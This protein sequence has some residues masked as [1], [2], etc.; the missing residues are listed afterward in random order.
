MLSDISGSIDTLEDIYEII[1]DSIADDPPSSVKDGFIIKDGFNETIDKLRKASKDG[2]KWIAE[3]EEKEREY[4][5][6]KSLKIGYTKVFGYY[7]EITNANLSSVP[8]DRY[9]RK[10]TLSNAERYITPELKEMETEITGAEEKVVQLEYQVFCEIRDK[11]AG[12]IERIQK[13]SWAIASIDVLC[14]LAIAAGEN[15]YIRP[16]ITNNGTILIKDGRH[17]VVEKTLPNNMFVPNDTLLDNQDNRISIITGPNMAGKS[18]Y[19]RQVALLIIMAQIGSFIP[20]SFAEIG[21]VDRI[22]TRIGASDDL[23]SGQSTFMVEMSEV[24]DIIKNSTKNSLILLDEVGRGT[25]TYDGL[26]IAWAVIEY[27][28]DKSKLGAKTL[29]ATHYHELTELE[30]R[31][32]GIKNYCISVKEHGDDIIFLRK[33]ILGGADK[34]YGIQVAKL[35][36]LPHDIIKRAREIMGKL[37]ENDITNDTGYFA[38]ANS[39]SLQNVP[40][41]KNSIKAAK[42][43]DMVHEEAAFTA[44]NN[45]QQ[46]DFFNIYNNDIIEELKAIDILNTT[47]MEAINILDRLCRKVKLR[48]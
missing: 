23:S 10:Q 31:I 45:Y 35:A 30:G 11:I 48:S 44:Q 22:F 2:K 42:I 39:L 21:V 32:D 27:I 29:F 5:G 1:N 24:A 41:R 47:P 38:F 8:Q 18:T 26:S 14:S 16:H 12:E 7:I 33:I 34:S 13:T 25:S 43:T 28:S 17:P 37:E 40:Q 46:L 6:I 4:T 20:A 9:I 19:M 36:G 3:L 15:D